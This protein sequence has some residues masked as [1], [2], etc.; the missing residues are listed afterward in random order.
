M[1]LFEIALTANAPKDVPAGGNYFHY[2]TG[3]GDITVQFIQ[4][5]ASEL[6]RA[7]AAPPGYFADMRGARPGGANAFDKIILTSTTNQTVKVGVARLYG[8]FNR[9]SASVTGEVDATVVRADAL[10]S[11]DPIAVDTTAGGTLI[12][13]ADPTRAVRRLYNESATITVY[14]I[15]QGGTAA[16]GIPL[17][18]LTTWTDAESAPA[19]LYG[20][21]SSGSANVRVLDGLIS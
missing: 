6:E 2:L 14:L 3:S 10:G 7:E 1:R 19:A 11:D 16:Q 9:T 12:Q 18:P 20:I 17:P 5:G 15:A 4:Q 21:T 8:G 13:A